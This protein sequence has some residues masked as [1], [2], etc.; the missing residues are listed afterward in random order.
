M[1][2]V[3]RED[4]RLILTLADGCTPADAEN[5]VRSVGWQA[6]RPLAGELLIRFQLQ[7]GADSVVNTAEIRIA[8]APAAALAA[9]DATALVP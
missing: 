5:L 2:K 9:P 1:A 6:P 4:G 7:S 8:P 3:T